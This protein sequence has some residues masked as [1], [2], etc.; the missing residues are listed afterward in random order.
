MYKIA[1]LE[2]QGFGPFR[3]R[4]V[5]Q[6]PDG[7]T[8]IVG[9]NADSTG[10]LGSNG[11]GKTSIANAIAWTLWGECPAGKLGAVRTHGQD[12]VDGAIVLEGDKEEEPPLR[13]RRTVRKAK[14]EA[15]LTVYPASGKPIETVGDVRKVQEII[16][17]KLGCDYSLFSSVLYFR[18]VDDTSQ[19]L[20]MPPAK[21]AGILS[22]IVDDTLFQI[23]SDILKNQVK[24]NVN[25]SGLYGMELMGNKTQ[26]SQFTSDLNKLLQEGQNWEAAEKARLAAA[27]LRYNSALEALTK[28]SQELLEARQY[29]E[30]NALQ[31]LG[32]EHR[33]AA[34]KVQ[35][36]EGDLR[37][38]QADFS[39]IPTRAYL[40][41][42]RDSCSMCGQE[43]Q[44]ITILQRDAQRA[45]IT[46]EMVRVRGQLEQSRV[47]LNGVVA[48]LGKAQASMGNIQL[49]DARV[50][51]LHHATVLAKD[52]LTP[53]DPKFIREHIKE[54]QDR[55]AQLQERNRVLDDL[56]I[57]RKEQAQ[58]LQDVGVAFGSEVRNLM[59][60]LVRGPLEE[61]SQYYIDMLLDTG[62]S[63]Q[64]PHQDTREKFEIWIWNGQ[65]CQDLS[66][67]SG[68]EMWR[69]SIAILLAFRKVLAANQNCQLDFLLLDD[70]AG[71]LDNEGV[72]HALQVLRKL[73]EHE[74][75][76]VLM[77][78]PREEFLPPGQYNR[79]EVRKQGG[80][81]KCFK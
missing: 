10:K 1:R 66:A 31:T 41:A 39:R 6:F 52:E 81:S 8:F 74:V 64:F 25:M 43:I 53:Q 36:L 2:I 27:Q 15:V 67:Y 49:L 44:E 33:V 7:L 13:V 65:H 14:H 62:I 50:D 30:E 4:Q 55:I 73:T 18:G 77:T 32:E 80:V 78:I 68:G 63:I 46:A 75:K 9:V 72:F 17:T 47:V 12:L 23:G 59:F 76:M 34:S 5:M 20:R 57:Q 29:C 79:I 26:I 3:D 60:D 16:N 40:E 21:R 58:V 37:V 19:F 54:Y 38:L 24:E 45:Q 71:E 42:H 51:D 22:N 56:L 11:S 48:R 70:F 61:W 35:E 69:I 28:V